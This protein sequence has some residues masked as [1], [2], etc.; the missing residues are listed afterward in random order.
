[1]RE[2]PPPQL[3]H[4]VLGASQPPRCVPA[5][6]ALGLLLLRRMGSGGTEMPTL[7]PWGH[8]GWHCPVVHV[9]LGE[10]RRR[11]PAH[12]GFSQWGWAVPQVL[13]PSFSLFPV[14]GAGQGGLGAPRLWLFSASWSGPGAR[15]SHS[16][17]A[18]LISPSVSLISLS[19]LLLLCHLSLP[20]LLFS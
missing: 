4:K 17:T 8:Q 2:Q 16:V 13:P 9:R 6:T 3:T 15:C 10:G 11:L 18:G 12:D 19:V 14:A 5:T 1:M 20:S 7:P